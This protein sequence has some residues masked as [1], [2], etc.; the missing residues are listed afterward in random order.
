MY[1]DYF[2]LQEMPFSIAPDPRFLYRSVRHREAL[3]HLLYGV[4]GEGGIVLLT[5]E[6]GTGKTTI[7]RCFLEEINASCDVAF[8]LNPRLSA[9]ELLAAICDE[10]HIERAPGAARVKGLI[11][12]INAHLLAANARGRRAVLII[13]EAQ[14]L[15]PDVLEQLRLLTNLETNTRKLL[16]IILIG[17]P[18]LQK[19][20]RR[21]ELRQVAQ[22][23][24]AR[25]H[26]THLSRAEVAAYVA[27]RLNV[28]GARAPIFRDSLIGTLY[29]VTGGVPR[30]INLVCD[31]ALLGTSVQGQLQVTPKTLRNAAREV[32]ATSGGVH[33]RSRPLVLWLLLAAAVFCGG[34]FAASLSALPPW[35]MAWIAPELPVYG[36]APVRPPKDAEAARAS[37]EAALAAPIDSAADAKPAGAVE[38]PTAGAT[39]PVATDDLSWPEDKAPRGRSEELAF[40]D[41][42]SLRGLVYDAGDRRHPCKAAEGFR[43]RCQFGRG[44]MADLR[45][46]DQPAVLKIDGG[47]KGREYHI[48]ITGLSGNTATVLVAGATRSVSLTQFAQLWSGMHVHLWDVPPGYSEI[49]ES[50][51]RGP[52]VLWLR[53]A[54]ARLQG[55]N[56]DGPAVFDE[57]LTRRVKAFQFAEG[58][59][60]DGAAGA[61]TLMRVNLRLDQKLPRL[62]P[63]AD[64]R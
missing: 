54:L 58:M 1:K 15:Q 47:G 38:T 61:L 26:L 28:S 2:C 14:N 20:L 24:V 22:R 62:A 41:L 56:A 29:R 10:F 8:I 36:S 21:P 44:G 23:V 49:L 18:E 27:H 30:L 63:I 52:A 25:Y 48:V 34:I 7:C 43:L 13:D 45:R 32:L 11:D 64:G 19:M 60:A 6:V 50:G 16:Q 9:K 39:A 31:R 40:R 33:L 37:T 3:A 42:L 17:Q 5:G 46:I 35:F 12:A 53:Q 57:D 55:G 4:Q 59:V 51:S